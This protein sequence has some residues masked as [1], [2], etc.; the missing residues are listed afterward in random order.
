MAGQIKALI[1][2]IVS[3]RAKGNETIALTTKTKILLKGIN[4]NQW[5]A[6]SPDDPLVI[7]KI[8]QIGQEL[9]ISV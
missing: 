2:K 7:T 9:G 4:P 5:T 1:D 8:K 3:Q 6:S